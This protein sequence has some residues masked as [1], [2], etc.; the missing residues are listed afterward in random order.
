MSDNPYQAPEAEADPSVQT[1]P[2][3]I[4]T[5]CVSIVLGIF[6]VLLAVFAVV[7]LAT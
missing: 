3:N 5:F 2:P 6:Y 1:D 4:L 7:A